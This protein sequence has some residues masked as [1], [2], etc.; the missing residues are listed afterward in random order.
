MKE[1]TKISNNLEEVFGVKISKLVLKTLINSLYTQQLLITVKEDFDDM[2][3]INLSSILIIV[4]QKLIIM[5][6]FAEDWFAKQCDEINKEINHIKQSKVNL[7]SNKKEMNLCDYSQDL[8]ELNALLRK[9]AKIQKSNLEILSHKKYE[10]LLIINKI[11]IGKLLKVFHDSGIKLR[12][13][14]ESAKKQRRYL[15]FQNFKL[16]SLFNAYSKLSF[17]P[18]LVEPRK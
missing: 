17:K 6:K 9:V 14:Q 5:S 16:S 2:L 4:T 3:Y 7:K 18:M 1:L 8:K 12:L 11:I 10:R 15:I 13:I